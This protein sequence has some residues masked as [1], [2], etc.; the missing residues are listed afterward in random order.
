MTDG[1]IYH[2]YPIGGM[3]RGADEFGETLKNIYLST[4]PNGSF[5]DTWYEDDGSGRQKW[6]LQ[7]AGNEGE[8]GNPIYYMMVSGGVEGDGRYLSVR[9]DGEFELVRGSLLTDFEK[10]VFGR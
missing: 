6:I 9:S 3:V 7:F 10:L 5:V 1:G 2:L 8:T 4:P